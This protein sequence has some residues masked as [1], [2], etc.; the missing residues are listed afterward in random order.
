MDPLYKRLHELK[1]QADALQ[2]SNE[3]MV[4]RIQ[5]QLDDIRTMLGQ[6]ETAIHGSQQRGEQ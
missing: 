4:L 6:I 3:V 2:S 1:T 5:Q